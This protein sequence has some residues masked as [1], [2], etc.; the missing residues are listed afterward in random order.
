[1]HAA[2]PRAADLEAHDT[3]MVAAVVDAAVNTFIVADVATVALLGGAVA[4]DAAVDVRGVRDT[5][6]EGVIG[7]AHGRVRLMESRLCWRRRHERQARQM[8][9]SRRVAVVECPSAMAPNKTK[10]GASAIGRRGGA[11]G[12]RIVLTVR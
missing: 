2:D 4:V 5:R 8:K 10:H 7:S 3:A 6:T 9:K 1:M 12:K 11:V